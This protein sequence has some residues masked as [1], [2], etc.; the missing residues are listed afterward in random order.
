MVRGADR[1]EAGATMRAG[2]KGPLAHHYPVSAAAEAVV[3]GIERRRRIVACP[4]GLLTTLMVLRPLLPRLTELALRRDIAEY[5]R[6]AEREAATSGSDPVGAGGAAE[7][8][9]RRR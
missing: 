5:D 4:R 2:L 3:R 9:G 6:I 1:T 8:A 7:L